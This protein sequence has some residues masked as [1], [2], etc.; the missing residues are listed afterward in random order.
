M[1]F[2]HLSS[3]GQT[4]LTPAK[5]PFISIALNHLNES[6]LLHP[7]NH[8]IHSSRYP[9]RSSFIQPTVTNW[10]PLA[11]ILKVWTAEH[12]VEGSYPSHEPYSLPAAS[13]QNVHFSHPTPGWSQH[14][15]M[16][17]GMP[18]TVQIPVLETQDLN[19]NPVFRDRNGRGFS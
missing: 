4:L 9:T 2:Y 3:N 15:S 8:T 10:K 1:R 6:N 11:S 17:C 12:V 13:K 5:T 19:A 14:E 7:H 18:Y 16:A